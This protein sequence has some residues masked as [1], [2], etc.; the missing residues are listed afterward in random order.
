ME[1]A[2]F[3]ASEDRKDSLALQPVGSEEFHLLPLV[4]K[5][6][7]IV[8]PDCLHFLAIALLVP[9]NRWHS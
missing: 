1:P 7:S 2:E 5:V 8:N 6:S 3:E 4:L 9:P